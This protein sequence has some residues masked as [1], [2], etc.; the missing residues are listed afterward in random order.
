MGA[1]VGVTSTAGRTMFAIDTIVCVVMLV[2]FGLVAL[3]ELVILVVHVF[4]GD[5]LVNELMHYFVILGVVT[6]ISMAIVATREMLEP[7]R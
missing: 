1:A 2:G 6:I 4:R 7:R 5:K 3:H